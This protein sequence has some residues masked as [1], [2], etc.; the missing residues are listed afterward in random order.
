MK[1]INDLR[2]LKYLCCV[3]Y[4][5]S[6]NPSNRA[7]AFWELHENILLFVCSLKGLG[8]DME[9]L[10]QVEVQVPILFTFHPECT[11]FI[12]NKCSI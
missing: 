3:L 9:K 11:Q 7:N 12:F 2:P 1:K 10:L 8:H 4:K 6:K 5:S